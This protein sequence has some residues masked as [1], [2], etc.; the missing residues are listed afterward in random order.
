MQSLEIRKRFLEFFRERGHVIVPSSSLIPSDPSV[1]L[2]TAGMQQFKPYYTGDADPMKDFGAKNTASTQKSFRTSDIDEVGDETHLTFFEMLG[3]FSF[4]GYGK[5]EA[6][7]YAHEF[8]TKE[9]GL[10]IDYVTV[11]AGDEKT[12][13][14]EESA[15]IWKILVPEKNIR[16]AGR[17]DNFWGP[18]GAEGPCGPTTE[19]YINGVEIWNIVFNEYYCGADGAFTKLPQLGIDTGMGLERLAMVAQK[20]K[21]IFETDLFDPFRVYLISGNVFQDAAGRIISDHLRASVFLLADGVK[22]SNKEAGYILRRLLRR[23]IVLNKKFGFSQDQIEKEME[24]VIKKYGGFSDY[25][26]LKKERDN[27]MDEFRI[28]AN[29]FNVTLEN[30]LREFYKKYPELKAHVQ[31]TGQRYEVHQAERISGKD[32]FDLYQTFGFPSDV[33][34]DL[35]KEGGHIFD[36]A[37]FNREFKKHQE[38]SRTGIEKKFGGHGLLLDTGELKAADE[39]EAKMVTRLHSATH[40]LQAALRKVLGEAVEQ[41][42]SDITAS[43]LRFDFSFARALTDNERAKVESIVQDVIARDYT[44]TIKKMTFAQA[45]QSGALYMKDRA[46]PQEVNVYQFSHPKTGEVFSSEI[47]GGPHV[48]HT[49]EIGIFRIT[50]QEAVGAGVRRVRAVVES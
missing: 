33:I 30:G 46:Y 28:E 40:L 16:K 24:E 3:N 32:A 29:K 7:A 5:K 11:F 37:E 18:T 23:A 43:R 36:E 34:K 20:K 6:I 50:K 22:P 1:L 13:A 45:Q 14:D 49:G 26:N 9:L 48:T 35:A 44:V 21:T 10:E 15:D 38:I 25:N 27:I 4:G 17:T 39:E 8:M 12:P 2:T 42:G 19:I 31:Q 47:C 41:R